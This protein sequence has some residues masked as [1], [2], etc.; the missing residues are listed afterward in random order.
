LEKSILSLIQDRS[1][2]EDLIDIDHIT[3]CRGIISLNPCSYFRNR[4]VKTCPLD[5]RLDKAATVSCDLSPIPDGL[6][7]NMIEF[8]YDSPKSLWLRDNISS[9]SLKR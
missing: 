3:T 4:I 8:K 7:E 9:G 5:H 6:T 1:K 2:K